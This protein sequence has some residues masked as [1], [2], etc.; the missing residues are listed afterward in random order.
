MIFL[1]LFRAHC[2]PSYFH[3]LLKSCLISLIRH[4]VLGL[5]FSPVFSTVLI[6]GFSSFTIRFSLFNRGAFVF[7]IF[8]RGVLIVFSVLNRLCLPCYFSVSLSL[9]IS[10]SISLSLLLFVFD[11]IFDPR[12]HSSSIAAIGAGRVAVEIRTKSVSVSAHVPDS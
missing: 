8:F 10:L 5:S 11:A 9:S 1:F 2:S 6:L 4:F 12:S 7:S 3:S